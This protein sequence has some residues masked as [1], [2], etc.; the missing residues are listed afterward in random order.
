MLANKHHPAVIEIYERNILPRYK[1]KVC[2]IC[3][4]KRYTS[5]DGE[6]RLVVCYRCVNTIQAKKEWVEFA[7]VT[8]G[9]G[10]R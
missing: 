5:K 1:K 4:G 10:V 6:N 2:K 7:K 3:Q 8:K 9:V